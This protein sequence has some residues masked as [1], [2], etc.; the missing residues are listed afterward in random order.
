MFCC[1]FADHWNPIKMSNLWLPIL[2]INTE[3]VGIFFLYFTYGLDTHT[4]CAWKIVQFLYSLVFISVYAYIR[5][6]A[7][8]TFKNKR[9]LKKLHCC[10]SIIYFIWAC[11][12]N[13]NIVCMF[14]CWTIVINIY[15]KAVIIDGCTIW[16]WYWGWLGV[17]WIYMWCLFI[18]IFFLKKKGLLLSNVALYSIWI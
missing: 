6:Y 18:W 14:M 17:M 8:I 16:C 12:G 1:F 10:K 2:H 11:L 9:P 3:V 4:E 5:I 13:R 15:Q 7:V